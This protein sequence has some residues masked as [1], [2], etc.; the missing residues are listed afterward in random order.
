ELKGQVVAEGSVEPEVDVVS[1][2]E[3]TDDVADERE[4]GGLL[5]PLLFRQ[6][7]LR[8]GAQHRE[9]AAVATLEALHGGRRRHGPFGA[10][11]QP[12]A[13]VVQRTDGDV[14]IPRRNLDGRVRKAEV[15]ARV[16]AGIVIARRQQDTAPA[17]EGI[18]D[19]LDG[20]AAVDLLRA[21]VDGD[22]ALRGVPPVRGSGVYD[23]LH[24]NLQGLRATTWQ[25]CGS[26][27]QVADPLGEPCSA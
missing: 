26:G 25:T 8:R 14:S 17:I 15:P 24:G 4:H 2:L 19:F 18:D 16:T 27:F 9:K 21:P 22:T 5:A 13:A 6:A 23:V 1:A 3:E 7:L 20:H 10:G 11:H 12:L